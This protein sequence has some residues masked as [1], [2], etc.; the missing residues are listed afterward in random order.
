MKILRERRKAPQANHSKPVTLN[1]SINELIDQKPNARDFLIAIILAGLILTAAFWVWP[2]AEVLLPAVKPF[3]PMFTTAI[4]LID[5]LTAY[6]LCLQAYNLRRIDFTL[7]AAAYVFTASIAAIQLLVFPGIFSEATLLPAGGQSAVWLWVLWHAGFPAFIATAMIMKKFRHAVPLQHRTA[8]KVMVLSVLMPIVFAVAIGY[9]VTTFNSSLIVLVENG[10]YS[11]SMSTGLGYWVIG[12][13]LFALGLIFIDSRLQSVVTLWLF[14]AVI[15]T[16]VDVV[17][18]LMGTERYSYGWYVARL[19]SLVSAS[20][21]L[22]ALLFEINRLYRRLSQEHIALVELAGKDSLTGINNR[23]SFDE[24]LN[25]EVERARREKKPISLLMIDIDYFKSVNDH[26]GH[27]TGD[28]YLVQVAQI[29]VK[30]C[31]RP[32]DFAARFGGEEFVSLLP[33]TGA[34]GALLVANNIRILIESLGLASGQPDER[35]QVVTVSIGTAT[36]KSEE[37]T[38]QETLISNADKAL[39]LAKQS[40]RNKVCQW[41]NLVD[42]A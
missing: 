41:P 9:F 26:F 40:G 18:T 31:K 20:T 4:V 28:Q 11:R 23:R 37:N 34:E 14:V 35:V 16:L 32:S 38:M 19:I 15:A 3:L 42:P 8:L 29:V 33:D 6:L 25:N 27:Q 10:N 24:H 7:L 13:N 22:G 2:R 5:S 39:Y 30:A 12:L 36:I 21:L 1:H 17:L